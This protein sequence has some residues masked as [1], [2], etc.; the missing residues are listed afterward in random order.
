M[1]QAIEKGSYVLCE[2]HPEYG[3]GR[4]IAMETFSARVL[5]PAGGLRLFRTEDL[6]RLKRAATPPQDDVALLET[7]EDELARGAYE[8]R[9]PKTP[10]PVPPPKKRAPRKKK[11][12]ASSSD[13]E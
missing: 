13:D 4:V 9:A 12:A 3:V 2:A 11:P 6:A 1:P 8:T 7:R 5:F 10:D